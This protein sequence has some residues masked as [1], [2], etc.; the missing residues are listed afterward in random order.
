VGHVSSTITVMQAAGRGEP[1]VLRL[2]DGRRVEVDLK[3]RGAGTDWEYVEVTGPAAEGAGAKV[4][5]LECERAR[6]SMELC[7]GFAAEAETPEDAA[8]WLDLAEA[9][10][11]LLEVARLWT[12]PS[13]RHH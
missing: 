4:Y 2:A 10:A 8:A 6:T 7:T 12:H 11:Q 9:W 3:H 1:A 13:G 5:S